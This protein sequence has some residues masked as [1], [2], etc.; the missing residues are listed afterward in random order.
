MSFKPSCTV[1]LSPEPTTGL[2]AAISGVV[3]PQPNVLGPEGSL[4]PA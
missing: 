1:R 3:Q 4:P 2:P